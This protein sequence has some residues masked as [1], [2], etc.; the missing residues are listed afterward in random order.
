MSCILVRH[1][2]PPFVLSV[3]NAKAYFDPSSLA[4]GTNKNIVGKY[5]KLPKIKSKFAN[6]LEKQADERLL[7]AL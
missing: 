6:F 5:Y 1:G 7:I 2:K 3:D 4:K